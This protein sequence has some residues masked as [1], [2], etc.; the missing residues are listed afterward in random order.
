[1]HPVPTNSG[2]FAFIGDTQGL[3]SLK[4]EGGDNREEPISGPHIKQKNIYR[5]QCELKV[6]F[7]N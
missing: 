1:M 3:L 6:I 5:E 2:L 4:D 7:L